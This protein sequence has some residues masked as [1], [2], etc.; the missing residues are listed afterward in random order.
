MRLSQVKQFCVPLLLTAMTP[1]LADAE[2]LPLRPTPIPQTTNGVPHMQIGI[3]VVPDLAEKLLQ[4]VA[5]FPGVSL[6]ETRISMPGVVGFQFD[7]GVSLARPDVIVGG[8]E[9]AHLHAD[10]SLHASLDPQLARTAIDAGWAVAHPWAM[11]RDGWEGF[12]M[13]FTPTTESELEVVVQLVENSYTF[14]TGRSLAN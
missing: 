14:I 9:F 8:L 11:Q 10:G 4:R 7:E 13:I 5:Q 2:S 1:A 3:D 6:G 12:V